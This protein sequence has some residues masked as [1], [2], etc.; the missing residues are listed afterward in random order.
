MMDPPEEERSTSAPDRP[1]RTPRKPYRRPVVH[2]YG[3]I[4]AITQ[5]I[6]PNGVMDGG[7]VAGMMM[8]AP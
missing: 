8:T 3:N 5:T 2:V 1:H 6:G 7:A 4:R